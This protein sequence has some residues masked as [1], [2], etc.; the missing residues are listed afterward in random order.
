MR[1]LVFGLILSVL[2]PAAVAADGMIRVES[3]YSVPETAERLV[4]ALEDAGMT[5]MARV[6]HAA[7][8]ESVD[9]SLRP[10]RVVIFGNPAAGTPLMRC[11]QTT[12]IDLPQKALIWED[13]DGTVW[14]GYNSPDYLQERH[15]ISGCEEQLAGV[16]QALAKFAL[17]ATGE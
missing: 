1:R 16:E 7:N 13:V 4:G 9:R 12:A 14:L 15:A 3:E 11:S 6:D 8:A 10:T 5:V 2:A 17:A